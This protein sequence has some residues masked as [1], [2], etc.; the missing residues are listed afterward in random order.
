M[1]SM[2]LAWMAALLRHRAQA[3]D[4]VRGENPGWAGGMARAAA[5]GAALCALL[6]FALAS[7]AGAVTPGPIWMITSVSQ[8]TRLAHGERSGQQHYLVTATNNV[9][10]ST[11]GA[12]IT[13]SDR[14]PVGLELDAAAA[15]S[16]QDDAGNS[17]KCSGRSTV[18]CIDAE[19]VARLQPGQVLVMTA[20]VRV[21]PKAPAEVTNRVSVSGGGAP[22]ASSREATKISSAPAR[23]GFEHVDG[24]AT[25]PNGTPDTQA[26]SRPWGLT[27]TFDLTTHLTSSGN[28]APVGSARDV[29]V[30]I[31]PGVIGNPSVVP[32][33][34]AQQ[35]ASS[36]SPCPTDSQVG[37]VAVLFADAPLPVHEAV[38]DMVPPPGMPAQLGFH[39]LTTSVYIDTS[40]RTGG[41]YGLDATLRNL[42][43][44]L[45]LAG[46]TLTLWGIPG[47]PSHD[48]ERCRTLF[49]GACS[50]P[51][52]YKGAVEPFVTLPTACLGPQKTIFRSNSWQKSG[53]V[54]S[55]SFVS[56]DNHGHP[57]GITGCGRLPFAP[58]L[59]AKPTVTRADS[60]AGISVDLR[61]PD[62]N[63]PKGLAEAQLKDATVTLPRGMSLSP[64]AAEGRKAC[65][66]AQI[67]LVDASKPTC[68]A[69]SVIGSVDIKTPLLAHPL[70]GGVYLAAQGRNPFGSLLA[71]YLAAHSDGVQVKLAGHVVP[72]R[73]TGQLTTTFADNPQLPFTDLRLSLSGGPRAALAMP[74]SCRTY[75][76]KSSLSP[77]SG[78]KAQSPSARFRVSAACV[79][80]FKPSFRAD[81]RKTAAGAFTAFSVSFSRGDQDQFFSGLSVKLPVGLLAKLA[82]VK[83]CNDRELAAAAAASGRVERAHPACPSSARV[84]YAETASGPGPSPLRLPGNVYLTGR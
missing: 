71:I 27:T 60:P 53:R 51:T 19:N 68:P 79:S 54:Q 25:E 12:A 18:T 55:G 34:N 37:V 24:W 78:T 70:T 22:R 8:P 29:S 42:P 9:G 58:A 39:I 82:G 64:P 69:S 50:K 74:D 61:L 40:V 28:L 56:H 26:G 32:R 13:I 14:L 36:T 1:T 33:C 76:T 7:K 72:N 57:V 45:Q 6:F 52:P 17:V 75:V 46:S 84:G 41:N 81:A 59:T 3:G 48:T 66:E 73:K 10:A 80:G 31:P 2:T 62:L 83:L 21:A 63:S 23:Y 44:S 16:G 67:G 5:L 49:T 43:Q 4:D 20:P 47:D 30:A 65:S 11:N 77:W 15:V 38:Y 35:L